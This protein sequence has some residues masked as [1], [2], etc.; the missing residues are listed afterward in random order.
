ML[1]V[2]YSC[3]KLGEIIYIVKLGTA[4]FKGE[5]NS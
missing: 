3:N 1:D 4:R 2:P 5:L